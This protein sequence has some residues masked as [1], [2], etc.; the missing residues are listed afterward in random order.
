MSLWSGLQ[1][2]LRQINIGEPKRYIINYSLCF[3]YSFQGQF[4][5]CRH[6]RSFKFLIVSPEKDFLIHCLAASGVFLRHFK[7]WNPQNM[8][9][10]QF[11]KLC[12]ELEMRRNIKGNKLYFRKNVVGNLKSWLLI[13]TLTKWFEKV[14]FLNTITS[15]RNTYWKKR[16]TIG[17]WQFKVKFTISYLLLVFLE[18]FFCVKT[19]MRMVIQLWILFSGKHRW[20]QIYFLL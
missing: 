5:P 16:L 20:W 12:G 2:W 17:R 3:L 7:F 13:I 15:V 8:A 4:A 18:I 9:Y 1:R 6:N 19:V 11:K 14:L 10:P